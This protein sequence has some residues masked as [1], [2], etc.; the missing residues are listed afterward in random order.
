MTTEQT[1]KRESIIS[2]IKKL[3]ALATS[4]NENE[5]ATAAE[6]AAKLQA[7]HQIEQATLEDAGQTFTAEDIEDLGVTEGDKTP[8]TWKN[9]VARSVA[10]INGCNL[11]Q[12]GTDLHLHGRQ[13]NVQTAAYTIRFL[14]K[15]IEDLTSHAWDLKAGRVADPAKVW[16]ES[17]AFGCARRIAA[18]LDALHAASQLEK[19]AALAS[20]N[21][22]LVVIARHELEVA[23]AWG[24]FKRANHL[25]AWTSRQAWPP[26]P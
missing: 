26:V 18:R 3:L 7:E 15:T 23:D 9:S 4:P 1:K 5:A 24:A 8:S 22:A 16:Q 11:W 25:Q 17:F 21:R 13:S 2:R 19:A 12:K 10:D 20:G 14:W 6:M